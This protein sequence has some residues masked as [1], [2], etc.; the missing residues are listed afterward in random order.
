MPLPRRTI[1][2]AKGLSLDESAATE[3]LGVLARKGRGKTFLAT[4]I[5]EGLCDL[6]CPTTIIDPAGN[7]WGLTLAANGKDPGLPFIVLGGQRGELPLSAE[8]G[9]RLAEVVVQLRLNVVLDVS[10][11]DDKELSRFV[12]DFLETF[13]VAS[14][15]QRQARMV[16][17]EE[18]QLL[19]P[20]QLAGDTQR[21][22]KGVE[23]IV[24]LGRNYG[25]GS[26]LI[27]QRPQSVNK[28]V[29][30]Q[31]ECLFV[32]QINEAHA[33]K[34]IRDWIAEKDAEAM[35]QLDALSKLER[36]EF[37]CWSPSWLQVFKKIRVLPKRTFDA[38][39]TPELGHRAAAVEPR[40]ESL[41]GRARSAT[42][43]ARR[44]RGHRP[45]DRFPR[46]RF[47]AGKRAA[48]AG[49]GGQ[50]EGGAGGCSAPAT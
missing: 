30:S 6:H 28:E 3:T 14:Q 21:M 13:R 33:R 37:F 10:E 9:H 43:G 45:L 35:S 49:G 46:R 2:I 19:A 27:S 47:G 29:L 8:A 36:G 12:G 1:E 39:R 24:R 4:K 20:Q 34:A 31:V 25:I 38:S 41:T 26:M 48:S 11:F 17:F 15:R 42:R 5:V 23:R 40:R 22:L 16:V 18:A 50:K 7:W 44:R 32:G